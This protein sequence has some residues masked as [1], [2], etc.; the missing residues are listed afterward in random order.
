MNARKSLIIF[1]CSCTIH[2]FLL[3]SVKKDLKNFATGSADLCRNCSRNRWKS[4]GKSGSGSGGGGGA[5]LVEGDLKDCDAG[6]LIN[7]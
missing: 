5:E 7:G 4:K 3:N 2:C 6:L 1:T